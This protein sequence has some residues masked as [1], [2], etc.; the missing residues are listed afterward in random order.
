MTKVIKVSTI[1]DNFIKE[2]IV[3]ATLKE[4][5]EYYEIN[6]LRYLQIY[7]NDAVADNFKIVIKEITN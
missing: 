3:K 4:L 7:S 5:L 6:K 1:E 2:T